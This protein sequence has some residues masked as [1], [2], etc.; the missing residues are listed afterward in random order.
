MALVL[1]NGVWKLQPDGATGPTTTTYSPNGDG[2]AT[3]GT[4]D[5]DGFRTIT[6][7]GLDG[8]YLWDPNEAIDTINDNGTR[9]QFTNGT[10]VGGNYPFESY[11]FLGNDVGI[12][13]ILGQQDASS[14]AVEATVSA[15]GSTST[16]F[17]YGA[18]IFQYYPASAVRNNSAG[19]TVY[20]QASQ[21]WAKVYDDG[22]AS[23]TS[24]SSPSLPAT[25]RTELNYTAGTFRTAEL[26]LLVGGVS[27][28]TYEGT[29]YSRTAWL[30][31]GIGTVV[32]STVDVTSFSVTV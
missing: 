28:A 16:S 10:V 27:Q 24:I 4:A 7:T 9:F 30:G 14:C 23:S 19:V 32:A 22:A 17:R 1:E 26:D 15:A 11:Q 18:G 6:N 21:M 13:L 12:V 20:G 5:A 31:F 3:L 2:D 8:L 25:L 29:P